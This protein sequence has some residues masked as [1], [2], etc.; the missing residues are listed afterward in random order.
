MNEVDEM[1]NNVNDD[2]DVEEIEE[3]MPKWAKLLS[4]KTTEN[5]N[6]IEKCCRSTNEILREMRESNFAREEKINTLNEK[7]DKISKDC[8]EKIYQVN[9]QVK[10]YLKMYNGM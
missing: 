4:L 10:K 3:A 8:S 6:K 1:V 5:M 9:I 2:L 7:L